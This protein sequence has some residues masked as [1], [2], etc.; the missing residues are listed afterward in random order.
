MEG[1]NIGGGIFGVMDA[2]RIVPAIFNQRGNYRWDVV[3]LTNSITH[4]VTVN[5]QIRC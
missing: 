5:D 2:V 1:E 4:D 3:V